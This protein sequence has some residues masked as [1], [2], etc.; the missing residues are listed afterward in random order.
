MARTFTSGS[1]TWIYNSSGAPFTG[2]PFTISVWMYPTSEVFNTL[3][4]VGTGGSNDNRQTLGL[5][6]TVAG[7]ANVIA[8]TRTT[9]NANA[10]ST[11]AYTTNKWQHACGVWASSSSRAAYLDGGGKGTDTTNLGPSAPNQTYIGNNLG[12][13]ANGFQNS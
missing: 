3:I 11:T 9:T 6:T 1:S 8:Q 12:L 4:S 10:Y 13:G 2:P 5:R 7:G